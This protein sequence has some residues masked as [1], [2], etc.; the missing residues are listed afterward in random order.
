MSSGDS[1]RPRTALV[2]SDNKLAGVPLV[3]P[4]APAELRCEAR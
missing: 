1:N 4:V 2:L 3:C